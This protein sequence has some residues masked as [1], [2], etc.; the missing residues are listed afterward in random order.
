VTSS[1]DLS[2][3]RLDLGSEDGRISFVG[4]SDQPQPQ[5]PPSEIMGI[6]V[7]MLNWLKW[8]YRQVS[9]A[10]MY[11]L[12]TPDAP[13]LSKKATCLTPQTEPYPFNMYIFSFT[14]QRGPYSLLLLSPILPY[15]K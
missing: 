1:Y 13:H 12:F 8:Y 14:I 3:W 15:Q 10:H 9:S 4:L 6:I 5:Y 11:R 2:F 7:E